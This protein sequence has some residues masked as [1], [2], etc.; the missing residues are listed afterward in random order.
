MML[1]LSFFVLWK[2]EFFV[3]TFLPFSRLSSANNAKKTRQASLSGTIASLV[4]CFSASVW[5]RYRLCTDWNCSDNRPS[6]HFSHR[7]PLGPW[8]RSMYEA[9]A[10]YKRS[11]INWFAKRLDQT[12]RGIRHE[13]RV[14]TQPRAMR[15]NPANADYWLDAALRIGSSVN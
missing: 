7:A 1:V 14:G 8:Q 12:E 4:I 6:T 10:L 5:L 13:R 11:G 9:A 15:L 3:W 2:S